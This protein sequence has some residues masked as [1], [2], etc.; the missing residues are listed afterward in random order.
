MVP[1]LLFQLVFYDLPI[2]ISVLVVEYVLNDAVWVD[3]WPESASAFFHLY[4]NEGC[5]LQKMRVRI[6]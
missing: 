4:H 5:E 3:P 2:W 1:H 6:V